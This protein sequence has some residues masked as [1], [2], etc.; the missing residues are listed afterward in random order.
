MDKDT[1]DGTIKSGKNP[2]SSFTTFMSARNYILHQHPE[3]THA[4]VNVEVSEQ[5]TMTMSFSVTVIR[6]DG[7]IEKD[8]GAAAESKPRSY[9]HPDQ[10]WSLTNSSSQKLVGARNLRSCMSKSSSNTAN[11]LFRLPNPTSARGISG[12]AT[13][14]IAIIPQ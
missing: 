5:I 10:V 3:L 2:I 4:Q 6:A 13:A 9:R 12:V 14:L 8:E 1:G 11:S 7:S